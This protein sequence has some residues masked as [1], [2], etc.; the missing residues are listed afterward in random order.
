MTANDLGKLRVPFPPS[1]VGK[2]PKG[3]ILLDFVGHGFL[4]ARFLDVDPLWTW[5][6]FALDANGLPL[7]DEF[8]GLW[9]NLTLCGMTRIGYGDAGGKK[10]PNAVKEAIGDALRNAGMRF[11]A[12]LDLWCK[13]DPDAPQPPSREDVERQEAIAE[14]KDACVALG[15]DLT[16][17]ANRF[18]AVYKKTVRAAEPKQIRDFIDLLHDEDEKKKAAEKAKAAA[19]VG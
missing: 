19:D 17:T 12:A 1:E 15:L 9:I 2:L 10:G 11:G 6:P 7:L 18:Y 8:G 16:G 5:E 14:L 4:T 13:G 3:G